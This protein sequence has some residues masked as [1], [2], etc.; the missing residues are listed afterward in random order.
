ML[1]YYITDNKRVARSYK[2]AREIKSNERVVRKGKKNKQKKTE[3]VNQRSD[4][5][6][7]EGIHSKMEHK[8]Y[9]LIR[10]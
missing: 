2:H 8:K 10:K 1:K 9:K 4:V 7:C 5:T 3:G 6:S